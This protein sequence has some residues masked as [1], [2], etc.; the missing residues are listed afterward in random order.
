MQCHLWRNIDQSSRQRLQACQ[1]NRSARWRPPIG[2]LVRAPVCGKGAFGTGLITRTHIQTGAIC[3]N[4]HL[5]FGGCHDPCVDKPFC[6]KRSCTGQ[7]VNAPVHQR[8]RHHGLV[9]LVMTKAPVTHQVDSHIA[10]PGLPIFQR[11]E[12]CTYHSFRV[13]AIDMQH[14]CFNHFHDIGAIQ[15]GARITWVRGGETNLVVEHDVDGATGVKPSRRSHTQGFHHH[16]LASNGGIAMNQHRHDLGTIVVVSA[17]LLCPHPPFHHRV[18]NFKVRRV[19]GQHYPD[20]PSRCFQ[21]YRKPLVI[22]HITTLVGPGFVMLHVFKQVNDGTTKHIVQYVQTPAVRH[23]QANFVN[24]LSGC[25]LNEVVE[26]GHKRFSTFERK[27]L[28]PDISGMQ[29]ALKRFGRSQLSQE[30]AAHCLVVCNVFR[31]VWRDITFQFFLYP[32][33][34]CGVRQMHVFGRQCAA[35]STL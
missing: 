21:F 27:P 2:M 19:E 8:L 29:R 34:L 17:L 4:H 35:V 25:M 6:V 5:G 28:L 30:P 23:A 14:R 7:G 31:R 24:A 22:L 33:F 16:T 15:A 1:G 32:A 9:L 10:S 18:H 20:R 26:H 3:L 12:H 13:I 11:D